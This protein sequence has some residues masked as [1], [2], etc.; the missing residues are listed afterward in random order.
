METEKEKKRPYKDVD[1]AL[2]RQT[3]GSKD[4]QTQ[5]DMQTGGQTGRHIKTDIDRHTD[6]V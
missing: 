1:D 2:K 3:A 6:G 4:R 5:T